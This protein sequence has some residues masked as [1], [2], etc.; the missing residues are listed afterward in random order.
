MVRGPFAAQIERCEQQSPEREHVDRNDII[1][2][3]YRMG[4]EENQVYHEVYGHQ[5]RDL[6]GAARIETP[7]PGGP[8]GRD[9]QQGELNVNEIAQEY[10]RVQ[11]GRRDVDAAIGGRERTTRVDRVRDQGRRD[12]D[13]E[14]DAERYPLQ[15]RLLAARQQEG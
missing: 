15:E 10:S 3:K 11:L 5:A 2:R 13:Q 9:R 7:E 4:H 14:G 1:W 8:D 12:P 6:P